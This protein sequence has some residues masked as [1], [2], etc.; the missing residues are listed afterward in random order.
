MAAVATRTSVH[1]QGDS[2]VCP[3][4][5]KPLPAQALNRYLQPVWSGEQPLVAVQRA[6]AEED[7]KMVAEGCEQR[8]VCRSEVAGPV[9][10][11]SERQVIV[12]SV[13]RAEAATATL[14]DQL[15][16]A[17][18]DVMPL[19]EHQQG[20]RV[21]RDADALQHAAQAMC[22]HHQVER[23]LR[24]RIEEQ[25]NER[26]VRASGSRPT[27]VRVE[28]RW[29][30]H[31]EVDEAAVSE[32]TRRLGRHQSSAADALPGSDR[33]G[34]PRSV[35]GGA[36]LWSLERQTALALTQGCAA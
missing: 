3:L 36:R 19:N 33:I 15:S 25:V 27:E 22:T 29:Q 30:R 12:R 31:R 34:L 4:A 18:A 8:V 16:K 14:H 17:Q 13:K 35:P 9:V 28:R 23:L 24:L 6:K 26:A 5:Q 2:S 20:K 11:W 32:A 7:D 10:I 1:A 21:Y